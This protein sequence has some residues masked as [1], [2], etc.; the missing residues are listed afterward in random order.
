[1]NN[2]DHEETDSIKKN[3]NQ[4]N[5]AIE[6]DPKF[7]NA[8]I[9]SSG[10]KYPLPE[11]TVRLRRGK[12]QRSTMVSGS[13]FLWDSGATEIMIK[14]K[15][16]KHH[17]RRMQSNKVEYSTTAVLYCTTHDVKATF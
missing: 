12:K 16:T 4:C 8:F 3:K 7:D 14:R 6:N 2:L 13:T 17:E 9:L 1:M 10:T 15:H 11:V 5:D